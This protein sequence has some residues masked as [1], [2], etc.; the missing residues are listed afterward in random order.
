M[1][2][3]RQGWEGP[4]RLGGRCLEKGKKIHSV[5]SQ[6]DGPE[7]PRVS[8]G[9]WVSQSWGGVV[10]HFR[11]VALRPSVPSDANGP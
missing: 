9:G 2:Q 11:F 6:E 1:R 5:P 10:C 8:G 3:S 4:E 7:V